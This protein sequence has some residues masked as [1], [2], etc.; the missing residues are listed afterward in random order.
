MTLSP[1][2]SAAAIAVAAAATFAT[3]L[4]PHVLFGGNRPVPRVVNYLG[5]MLPPAI[6]ATLV[7]Y[8]LRNV[9]FL[10]QT[11]G[12]PEIIAV[13]AVA[14]AGVAGHI[15]VRQKVHFDLQGSVALAG[16][17]AA[18]LEVEGKAILL[19]AADLG[20]LGRGKQCADIGKQPGIGCRIGT[21]R[22]SDGRLVDAYDLI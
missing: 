19:E 16:F 20:I 6:I 5:K 15:H 12:L 18:A 3:R 21:R 10:G 1:L 2:M 4:I 11:H 17:A 9:D 8:C 14:V 22:A 13:I 7:V